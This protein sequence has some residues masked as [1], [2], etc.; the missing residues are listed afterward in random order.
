MRITS[1]WRF[2]V[3]SVGGESVDSAMITDLGV[4]GDRAWGIVDLETTKVLTGRREAALLLAEAT[5][6]GP[7]EVSIRLPDGTE[8]ANDSALSSWLGHDVALT[9]AGEE[10]GTY[11]VPLDFENEGDWV[12]WQG[13]GGAWHD[14]TRSRVSLVSQATLRDWDLRRFRTNVILDGEGEDALVGRSVRLGEAVL[15]VGKQI[16]RCVMV[17]RPLPGIDRDL[18]ILKTINRER[19]TFLAVGALVS[20]PGRVGVGDELTQLGD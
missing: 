14:S 13:P 12:S 3:K 9:K 10:G 18:E 4:E 7:D 6:H 11:E 15:N 17:T 20:Q 16:D 19:Q 8:T 5:Y 1:L 2:P